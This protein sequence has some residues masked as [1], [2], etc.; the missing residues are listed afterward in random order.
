MHRL[1]VLRLALNSCSSP[2]QWALTTADWSSSPQSHSDSLAS[3]NPRPAPQGELQT[4][5]TA[6]K[7]SAGSNSKDDA[8]EETLQRESGNVISEERENEK[9]EGEKKAETGE[10]GRGKVA[11]ASSNRNGAGHGRDSGAS[12]GSWEREGL[13]PLLEVSH[14]LSKVFRVAP[15]LESRRPHTY[16]RRRSWEQAGQGEQDFLCCLFFFA[17]L[18]LGGDCNRKCGESKVA[19]FVR[20]SEH[21]PPPFLCKIS[22]REGQ[23]GIV[24]VLQ[25]RYTTFLIQCGHL[26]SLNTRPRR[27]GAGVPGVDEGRGEGQR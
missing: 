15:I 18:E 7:A 6:A 3:R 10:G 5:P 16:A 1:R 9:H 24:L 22:A 14:A 17:R 23:G 27:C 13:R 2:K 8:P 20:W 19:R 25:V 21:S 4:T 26:G 11:A 12:L